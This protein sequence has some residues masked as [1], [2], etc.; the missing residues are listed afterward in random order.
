MKQGRWSSI[1]A[2]IAAVA[3]LGMVPV[4]ILEDQASA[5]TPLAVTVIRP[6]AIP[7][8]NM[9]LSE[10]RANAPCPRIGVNQQLVSGGGVSLTLSSN[11]PKVNGTE[12][13][14]GTSEM[15]GTVTGT[16]LQEWLGVGGSGGQA[17][18]AETTTP[19]AMCFTPGT[20]ITGTVVVQSST[21][22]PVSA[23][24]VSLTAAT[25]PAG[26]RLLSG[27]ART[28]SSP[29]GNAKPIASYPA[30]STSTVS[31]TAAP[32]GSVNPNQW[33]A[34]GLGGGATFTASAINTYAFAV[35]TAGGAA[36]VTNTVRFNEASGPLS[37]SQALGVTAT[38][39]SGDGSAV[40]GGA[41]MDGGNITTTAF[42]APGSQGDHLTGT[43]PA[44]ANGTPA[45]TGTT[46]TT[47]W[48]AE[49]HTGGMASANTVS[50]VWAMCVNTT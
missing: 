29:A 19:F 1:G 21:A 3:L 16:S 40:G 27:G 15:T 50:D 6:A 30:F 5:V 24:G 33:V 41:A 43:F 25:C 49:T 20:G 28:A 18:A 9:A 35:C 36:N 31:Y 48:A 8:P 45:V 32:N 14:N 38:C 10:V 13:W 12:P 46:T 23:G 11:S 26:D 17:D 37:G 7:G 44:N 22:G 4:L 39:Q 47:V 34:V 42:T 2:R